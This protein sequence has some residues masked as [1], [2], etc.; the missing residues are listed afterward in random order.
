LPADP[1][2]NDSCYSYFNSSWSGNSI[3]GFI[4]SGSQ[5][6]IFPNSTSAPI[7][8]DSN[9]SDQD[10]QYYTPG[11]ST[12]YSATNVGYGGA[13]SVSTSF[14]L[15]NILSYKATSNVY[16]KWGV[17]D[18]SGPVSGQFDW[19]LPF[20]LG[21]PVFV[22]LEG[23]TSTLGTGIYWSYPSAQNTATAFTAPT[24]SNVMPVTI[25]GYGNEPVVTVTVCVP[26]TQTCVS[27]P[28]ILLDT[29]SSGLR[30]FAST[31]PSNFL[32]Q[33]SGN[34]LFECVSYGDNSVQW[35]AVQ[36]ADIKMGA[37]TA[38]SVPIHIVSNNYGDNGASCYANLA[39]LYEQNSYVSITCP[40]STTPN[41]SA[42]PSNPYFGCPYFDSTNSN[43]NGILGVNFMAQDC[44]PT[45][46]SNP[47]YL[48]YSCQ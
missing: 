9:T 13:P 26:G 34:G 43:Y 27:I 41:Q 4:D 32:S 8:Y 46:V 30:L 20:F 36:T 42:D 29:G 11:A 47:T 19:G 16:A 40:S 39:S 15:E 35:G 45:C 33:L 44:G 22:G 31:V 24:G 3:C 6:L 10:Y 14:T 25:G 17:L 1:N 38:S 7:S 37:Q 21:R 12:N 23:T 2:I 48:Y 28:N 5:A 18:S